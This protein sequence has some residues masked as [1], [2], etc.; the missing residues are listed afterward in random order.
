MY[1]RKE[2]KKAQKVG[3]QTYKEA[4]E[5]FR[6]DGG[7]QY[8]CSQSGIDFHSGGKFTRPNNG[9]FVSA[10]EATSENVWHNKET[11]KVPPVESAAIDKSIDAI[12]DAEEYGYGPDI[13]VKAFS[14]LDLVLF[15][16]RLRGNFCVQWASHEYFRQ[17]KV[18]PGAWDLR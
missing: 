4:F 15:N 3:Q 9:P 6:A 17:R 14:D 16:G 7:T 13:I 8:P 1:G 10:A 11:R 5:P 12:L 2:T 18:P